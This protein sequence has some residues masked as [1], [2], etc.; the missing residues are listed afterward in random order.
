MTRSIWLDAETSRPHEKHRHEVDVAIIGGGAVGASCAYALS[1]RG[2]KTVIAEGGTIASGASGRNG[3]FVLRGLQNYYNLAIKSYGRQIAREVYAFTDENQKMM[4]EFLEQ[5][6]TPFEPCG[7]Y[8]LASSL[9]ELDNL[10]ES[11][12]LLNEDGFPTEYLK[13]DPLERDFYGALSNKSDIAIDPVKLVRALVE[14]SQAEVLENEIVNRVQHENGKLLL[15]STN[16]IIVCERAIL[17]VNGYAPLFAASFLDKVLPTRGQIIVT[18]PLRER[19]VDRLCYANYGW[20][21]FRQLPDNRLLV[22]GCRQHFLEQENGYAD[23]VSRPV[24]TALENYMKDRF[25]EIAGVRID[26]RF[27]GVMGFTVDGLPLVGEMSKHPG[28]FYAVGFNGHGFSYAMN[29]AELLVRMALDNAKPGV[30]DAERS[31]SPQ[32]AKAGEKGP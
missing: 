15:H 18:K 1:K 5:T 26:Y 16:R 27:S 9:E 24:Q 20:E 22:G 31:L 11:A 8:V 7:S 32:L 2:K 14:R 19:L 28:L 21:Y 3:G 23:M 12:A 25:P 17:A 6:S 30:F 4:V 13:D 10:S 29:I